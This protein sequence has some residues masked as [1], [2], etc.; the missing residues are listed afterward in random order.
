MENKTLFAQRFKSARI[1]KGFSLQDLA[2]ALNN[3]LSRQALHRYEKAEVL[4]DEE[5]TMWLAE[6]LS[7]STG[8]FTRQTNVELGIIE[9]RKL[10]KMSTKDSSI[11]T[12]KTKDYLSRYLELEEYLGISEDFNDPLEDFGLVNSFDDVNR[13]AQEV[14]TF[15]KLGSGPLF[16]VVQLLEDVQIKVVEIKA[17]DM[18]DGL[19]TFVN[20]N[21]PVIAYN[22]EKSNKLDRIRFTLLHELG[23][24]LLKF[25]DKLV[26]DKQ[27]ER[28]CNQFAGA[29][30]MPEITIKKE[31]GE[32][33]NK[34]SIEELGNIKKQYGISMQALVMR[35]LDCGI[36]NKHY[37][38]QFFF[39]IK[40][41]N[42]KIDEPYEYKGVE[43]SNRFRQLLFRAFAEE[44]IT[45]SKAAELNN[46]S[47]EEFRMENQSR[48]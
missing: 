16:N 37:T 33:R 15:W 44:Q 22:K 8:F 9:Y 10:S 43:K 13:A 11:I 38:K 42:W 30:L 3:K 29:M 5:K 40:Q 17:D 18:F 20:G 14:R 39:L 1:M 4:P 25:D 46:Q 34:L 41:Q 27:K 36:I 24:L 28:Y 48:F 12:E 7:V 32:F 21:I 6:A 19:Q 47:F 2:D 31:L 26:S 45:M 35:A 23:H